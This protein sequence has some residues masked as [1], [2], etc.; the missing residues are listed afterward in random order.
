MRI[1]LMPKNNAAANCIKKMGDTVEVIELCRNVS[2]SDKRDWFKCKAN[3]SMFGEFFI[4]P[5]EDSN[6]VIVKGE[7]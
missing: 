4:H 5:T 1:K 3:S 2:F 6:F 7:L